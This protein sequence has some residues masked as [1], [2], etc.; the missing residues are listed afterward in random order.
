MKDQFNFFAHC[1]SRAFSKTIIVC[2]MIA[3]L[4]GTSDAQVARTGKIV[5]LAVMSGAYNLNA[6]SPNNAV[7][8]AWNRPAGTLNY[9]AGTNTNLTVSQGASAVRANQTESSRFL[10]QLLKLKENI[11]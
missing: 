7:I 4:S 9:N 6:A 3:A 11:S 10:E 2:F 5:G 8:I 1:F